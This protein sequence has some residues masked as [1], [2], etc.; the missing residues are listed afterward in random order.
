MCRAPSVREVPSEETVYDDQIVGSSTHQADVANNTDNYYL[1][2][3]DQTDVH[4]SW[5]LKLAIG[6]VVPPNGSFRLNMKSKGHGIQ[7][8]VNCDVYYKD[9][10]S[11]M[12]QVARL[13]VEINNDGTAFALFPFVNDLATSEKL[14]SEPMKFRN[15]LHVK[16]VGSFSLSIH[17]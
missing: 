4:G 11:E 5:T 8:E 14:S 7:G 10:Q 1:K 9:D 6:S 17:S 16:N 15:T 3:V 12:I 13:I 2:I